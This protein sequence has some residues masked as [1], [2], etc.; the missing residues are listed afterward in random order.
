MNHVTIASAGSGKTRKIVK[1]ALKIPVTDRVLIVTYTIEN[2]EELRNRIVKEY[3]C[4]PPNI[5][6]K[7]WFS[8]L[9]TDCV[10]P[11]QNYM[12]NSK[13]IKNILFT[14][15][16]SVPYIKE[17]NTENYYLYKGEFIYSDKVSKFAWKCNTK[18]KGLVIK[19][20]EDIYQSIYIDEVQD[21]AGYDIEI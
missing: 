11:Y 7:T 1:E 19:R 4:I 10:R 6:V 15:K 13:R 18:S 12:Y 9:L 3:G 8:F 17:S 20:L 5:Q 16:Q 2:T 21:L 14:S